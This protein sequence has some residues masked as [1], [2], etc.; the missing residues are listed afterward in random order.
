MDRES[1]DKPIR[2]IQHPNFPNMT[3]ETSKQDVDEAKQSGTPN[4]RKRGRGF[5]VALILAIILWIIAYSEV[6]S[7]SGSGPGIG[8]GAQYILLF[9]ALIGLSIVILILGAIL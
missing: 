8:T 9:W 5:P 1:K 4:R 7:A 6:S 2:K 3:D